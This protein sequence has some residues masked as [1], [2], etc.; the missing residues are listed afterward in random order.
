VILTRHG[1]VR[2]LH[3]CGFIYLHPPMPRH[4]ITTSCLVL[5]TSLAVLN[6][7]IADEF[8]PIEKTMKFAHKAPKGEKKVSDRIIEGTASDQEITETL[9]LYKAIVDLKPPKGEQADF[10]ARVVKVVT[11]LED[12]KAKK[13]GAPSL[14]KDAVNCKAC[15]KEHKPD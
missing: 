5:A 1:I 14:F 9:E 7:A 11:A 8:E 4:T 15:H 2:E 10:H 13:D 3:I 6:F 12:V